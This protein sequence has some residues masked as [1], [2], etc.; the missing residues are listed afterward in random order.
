VPLPTEPPLHNFV[1]NKTS[2]FPLL[3]FAQSPHVDG[4]LL[5]GQKRLACILS[6]DTSRDARMVGWDN[7]SPPPVFLPWTQSAT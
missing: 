6:L 5:D 2:E 1:I 7:F 3:F 4:D